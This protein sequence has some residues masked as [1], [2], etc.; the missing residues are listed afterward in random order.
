MATP[1]SKVKATVVKL[2]KANDVYYFFPATGGYGRSGVPDI[3]ACV[4]GRFVAIECKANGNKPTELQ[5]RELHKIHKAGGI[6]FVIDEA[7]VPLIAKLMEVAGN[8]SE[9]HDSIE[10]DQNACE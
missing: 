1:E 9:P 2:L 6:T 3:I 10:G 5:L 8:W 7:G 4:K